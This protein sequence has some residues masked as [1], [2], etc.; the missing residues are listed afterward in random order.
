MRVPRKPN[1]H[2][3]LG[4][5]CLLLGSFT[6]AQRPS[7]VENAANDQALARIERSA[8]ALASFATDV[9]RVEPERALARI[10][11]VLSPPLQKQQALLKFLDDQQNR[12][13]PEYHHWLVSAE[14]GARFGAADTDTEAVRQWLQK[15][16]FQVA[17]ASQ[18]RL[19]VEFSGTAQQVESAFHIADR[20]AMLYQGRLIAVDSKEQFAGNTHP[21]IRQFLDRQPDAAPGVAAEEFIASYLRGSKDDY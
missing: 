18:S 8:A 13:S 21:R 12:R 16:G 2:V 7:R 5:C 10:V 9:G 20:V 11:L 6:F 3:P 17:P 19:W 4:I 1:C 15:S 14:F